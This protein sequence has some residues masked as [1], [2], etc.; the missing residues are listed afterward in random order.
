MSNELVIVAEAI[1]KAK[2]QEWD[3]PPASP[4]ST[5]S[6]ARLKNDVLRDLATIIANELDARWHNFDRVAWM[7]D[8]GF[9]ED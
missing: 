7:T 4:W 2:P 8:C 9:P 1:N 3:P 6:P 5:L